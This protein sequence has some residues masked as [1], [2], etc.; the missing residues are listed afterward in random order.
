MSLI[1]VHILFFGGSN[2]FLETDAVREYGNSILHYIPFHV[3]ETLRARS[4]IVKVDGILTTRSNASIRMNNKIMHKWKRIIECL[5]FATIFSFLRISLSV[6]QPHSIITWQFSLN[7][8]RHIPCEGAE[9]AYDRNL[10]KFYFICT[11]IC[12]V[13]NF[14]RR[15]SLNYCDLREHSFT[16]I[17]WSI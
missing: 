16:V 14:H 8:S 3:E 2:G 7:A 9:V 13:I 4:R 17:E 15:D 6:A 12:R 5:S 11:Y 10:Q 1:V